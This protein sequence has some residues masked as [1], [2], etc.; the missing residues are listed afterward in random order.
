LSHSLKKPTNRR[1]KARGK[2]CFERGD[3]TLPKEETA[4]VGKK[5]DIVSL[6]GPSRERDHTNAVVLKRD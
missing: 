4:Y 2:Q 3:R 5:R 6:V 1:V